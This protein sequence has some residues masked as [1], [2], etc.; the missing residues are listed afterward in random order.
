MLL[1]EGD[2]IFVAH[3]RLFEKDEVRFFV[4]R[5]DAYE[6]GVVKATGRSYV[7]DVMR[8]RMIE[9]EEKRTKILS[10][11]SGTLLV[12]QLPEAVKVDALKFLDEEGRVSLTDGKNF[13]MN[14]S[15]HTHG[16]RA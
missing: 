4:G 6:G 13:T 16:G 5:V 15:E 7:R 3:R 12:Y 2:T 1:K 8:G 11:S 14:L 9:K 10:L